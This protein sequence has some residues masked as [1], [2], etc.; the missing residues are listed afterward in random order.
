MIQD[1]GLAGLI[2]CLYV[3]PPR[4][5]SVYLMVPAA[6]VRVGKHSCLYALLEWLLGRFLM[7]HCMGVGC[8]ARWTLLTLT[9]QAF[10]RFL[11]LHAFSYLYLS[12]GH[13]VMIPAHCSVPST[14]LQVDFLAM[15][16]LKPQCKGLPAPLLSPK[17]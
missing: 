5:E 13:F 3:E 10:L 14:C 15:G 11:T 12:S 7:A 9:Q 16:L 17:P 1:T 6:G 4:P 8:W 2:S